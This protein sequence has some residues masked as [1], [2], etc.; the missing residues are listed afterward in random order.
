MFL[1]HFGDGIDP[2]TGWQGEA[3]DVALVGIKE[4][5]VERRCIS[6]ARRHVM[7]PTSYRETSNQ[8]IIL[9]RLLYLKIFFLSWETTEITAMTADSGVLLT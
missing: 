8:G 5:L 6:A 2:G 7:D 9:D 4:S 3:E 1:L